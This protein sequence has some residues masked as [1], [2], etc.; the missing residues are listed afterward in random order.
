MKII[1]V[2]P[3][4]SPNSMKLT[5]DTRLNR[6]VRLDYK[7][8]EDAHAPSHIRKL[9][10]I[11]G[12]TGVFQTADFLALERHPKGDWQAILEAAGQVLGIAGVQE[13]TPVPAGSSNGSPPEPE[14]GYG[15]VTLLVQTYRGIPMQVRISSGLEE[16]RAALPDRFQNAAAEAGLA[17]PNLIMERKLEDR[18]V[19]Y[20]ELQE[21]LE[22]VV[23]ELEASF[24]DLRLREL[25]ERSHARGAPEDRTG[26]APAAEGPAEALADPDWRVRYAA[27]ERLSPGP[28][29]L[30]LLLRALKDPHTSVRRLAV[31]YTGDIR[32]S[33]TLPYLLEA[34]RDPSPMIRRTAGDTLSDRGDPAA[35][36]AMEEALSDPN[37]LVRWRAARFLY[38]VGDEGSIPALEKAKNDPEFE[39]RLQARLALERIAGGEEAQGTVW[40]QMTRRNEKPGG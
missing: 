34:L 25:V 26:P 39:I 22:E 31:V 37:K 30:P 6:G 32:E 21:V 12:V 33:D 9:L 18:G 19:R 8:G 20:G 16:K 7:A 3:T 23:K 10:A 1:R 28:D 17:S 35:V 15:E 14:K 38:E 29:T 24:D 5:L 27:L 36:P 2:E 11:P 4:P 40:Q 13:G